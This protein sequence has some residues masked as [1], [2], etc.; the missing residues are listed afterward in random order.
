MRIVTSMFLIGIL[1]AGGT[2]FHA[3]ETV[4]DTV[5]FTTLARQS[6]LESIRHT[7]VVDTKTARALYQFWTK[8]APL[9]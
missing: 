5:L 2:A 3:S 7:S 1:M 6:I 9:S 8:N 4:D